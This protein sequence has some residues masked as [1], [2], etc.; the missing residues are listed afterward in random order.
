MTL[1]NKIDA[2]TIVIRANMSPRPEYYS[3]RGA[4]LSDLNGEILENIYQ[5][6]KKEYGKKASESFVN[7]VKDIPVAS[8]TDFLLNLYR[9]E[10]NNWKWNEKMLGS[11]KGVYVDGPND[12]VKFAVGMATIAGIFGGSMDR[13]D[14]TS[15]KNY[16][17]K[18][19]GI[20]IPQTYSS[21]L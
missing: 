14:T 7:M 19:H 13:D 3:G 12:N 8:A 6:I 20:E 1:E 17:L 9:L 10:S 2:R 11:E 18:R 5:G 21:N 15:I 4:T 16:F